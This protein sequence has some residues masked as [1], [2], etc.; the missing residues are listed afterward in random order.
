MCIAACRRRR[1]ARSTLGSFSS[2]VAAAKNNVTLSHIFKPLHRIPWFGAFSA[3]DAPSA[4]HTTFTQELCR[5]IPSSMTS[6]MVVI[7]V[8]MM[9]TSSHSWIFVSLALDAQQA[10]LRLESNGT[11]SVGHAVPHATCRTSKRDYSRNENNTI[12]FSVVVLKNH[13]VNGMSNDFH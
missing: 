3:T 10:R 5:Y 4:A 8:I 6:N 9:V 13:E 11:D 12:R 2:C 7:A 1:Q